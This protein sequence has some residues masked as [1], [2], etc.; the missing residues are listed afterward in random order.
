MFDNNLFLRTTGAGSLT[1]TETT[2]GIAING[3]PVGGLACVVA[4]PKQSIG[5]TV[6]VDVLH[7]TDN[8]TYTT[9]VSFETLA[10]VTAANTNT[11][12][13][14]RRFATELKYVAAQ[15]TVAGTSPDFGAVWCAI[16]DMD[17]WNRLPITSSDNPVTATP[18]FTSL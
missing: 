17:Q 10:S 5:D 11:G 16:G 8:S 7:S 15:F 2:T 9:L 12:V 14:V 1:Q 18:G 6:Q 4:I 13:M 3:T